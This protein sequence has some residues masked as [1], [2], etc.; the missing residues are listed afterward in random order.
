MQAHIQNTHTHTQRREE[1]KLS[2]TPRGAFRT[3]RALINQMNYLKIPVG[4]VQW[5]VCVCAEKRGAVKPQYEMLLAT[6]G[7]CL[8]CVC[9][10]IKPVHSLCV[11]V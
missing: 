9:M 2:N 10:H 11:K 4:D 3:R 6:A 1:G 7:M 5:C 8:Q